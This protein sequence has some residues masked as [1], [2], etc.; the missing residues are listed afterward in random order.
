MARSSISLAKHI[1]YL[2]NQNPAFPISNTKVQKVLYFYIGL[3]LANKIEKINIID[4]LPNAFDNGPMFPK[5]YKLIK[6]EANIT[7][8]ARDYSKL[9][10]EKE[11]QIFHKTI[12]LVGE[13]TAGRLSHWSHEKGSPWDIVYNQM[14]AR[15]AKIPLELIKEYFEDNIVEKYNI[16]L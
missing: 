2:L 8:L 10:S 15:Y 13:Y 4:E 7:S 12:E 5:V 16:F 14:S 3:A 1:I 6:K 9:L 11:N